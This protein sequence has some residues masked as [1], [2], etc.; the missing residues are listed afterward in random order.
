MQAQHPEPEPLLHLRREAQGVTT[1][2]RGKKPDGQSIVSPTPKRQQS[3][4]A[5]QAP[6][7]IRRS[8]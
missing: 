6:H 7:F 8:G 4:Q 5:T 3:E 2:L 1:A